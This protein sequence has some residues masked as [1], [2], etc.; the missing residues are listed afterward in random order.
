MNRASAAKAGSLLEFEPTLSPLFAMYVRNYL[1]DSGVEPRQYRFEECGLELGF[2]WRFGQPTAGGHSVIGLLSAAGQH[3]N[4]EFVGMRMGQ[5]Y[6]YETPGILISTILSAPSVEEAI[7]TLV[8]TTTGSSTRLFRRASASKRIRPR[9]QPPSPTRLSSDLTQLNE[10]LMVFIVNT[11]NKATRKPVP[12]HAGRD[13]PI[14][15]AARQ[16]RLER[17]FQTARHALG[18]SRNYICFDATYLDGKNVL[19]QPPAVRHLGQRHEDVF[20]DQQRENS[21]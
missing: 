10:Y 17:F 4:N 1:L 14:R 3:T 18:D 19:Q 11:L 15:G 6:H 5:Q 16:S 12:V 8:S 13:L 21:I 9:L 2:G 20:L 7:R